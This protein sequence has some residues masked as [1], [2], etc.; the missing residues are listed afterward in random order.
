MSLSFLLGITSTNVVEKT[1][2][3]ILFS[4]T[5]LENHAIYEITWKNSVEPYRP[6]MTIWRMRIACRITKATDTHTHDK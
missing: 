6:Q 3:H 5:V 4:V 2:I 1:K